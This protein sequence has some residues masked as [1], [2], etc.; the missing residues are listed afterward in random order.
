MSKMCIRLYQLTLI[1]EQVKK[2]QAAVSQPGVNG[3]VWCRVWEGPRCFFWV[4]LKRS[5]PKPDQHKRYCTTRFVRHWY[6]I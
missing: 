5:I 1:S 2:N 4:L 3:Q 6:V